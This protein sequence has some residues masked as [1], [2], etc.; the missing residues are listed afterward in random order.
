[1]ISQR[2]SEEEEERRSEHVETGAILVLLQTQLHQSLLV[3]HGDPVVPANYD[4]CVAK[5]S[6][7]NE[8]QKL[9]E[10][11]RFRVSFRANS[12]I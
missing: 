6:S 8:M 1:M 11:C 5:F 3:L 9:I 10:I 4:V 2:D 7:F 12:E